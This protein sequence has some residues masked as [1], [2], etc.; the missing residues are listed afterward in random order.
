MKTNVYRGKFYIFSSV[1]ERSVYRNHVKMAAKY[2]QTAV[3][4]PVIPLFLIDVSDPIPSHRS[5]VHLRTHTGR[6]LTSLV[7][8]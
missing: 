6:F 1:Y 3:E 8:S 7:S 4:N 2:V 5:A